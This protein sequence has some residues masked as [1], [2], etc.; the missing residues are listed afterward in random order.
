[1]I[2]KEYLV[3]LKEIYARLNIPLS[4]LEKNKVIYYEVANNN[5]VLVGK[6]KFNRDIYLSCEASNAW[7]L[8]DTDARKSGV[9]LE[10]VSGYR[11]IEYQTNLI[12]KKIDRGEEIDD[13]LKVNAA[14]GLSEHHTGHAIDFS[15]DEEKGEVLTESFENTN[16]FE[17]L[18]KFGSR[19]HFYMTYPRNNIYGY[20]YEPWHWC[21]KKL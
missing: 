16:A 14:P 18:E 13:I 4:I 15:S 2:N 12:S 19:Y 9:Y 6:D 20:N 21:Y 3:K 10:I 17:W 7:R 11:S 1:M 5:I 8:M